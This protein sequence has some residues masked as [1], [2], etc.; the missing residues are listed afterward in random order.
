MHQRGCPPRHMYAHSIYIYSKDSRRVTLQKGRQWNLSHLIY[1]ISHVLGHT[2]M[3]LCLNDPLPLVLGHISHYT[4]RQ[5][6]QGRP[7]G[8]TQ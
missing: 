6:H 5:E 1:S 8:Y 7:C 2:R 3:P 4:E